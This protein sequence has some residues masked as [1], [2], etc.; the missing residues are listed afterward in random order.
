MLNNYDE[1]NYVSV[2]NGFNGIYYFDEQLETIR[3]VSITNAN[4]FNLFY[5]EEYGTLY[6][7]NADNI[8]FKDNNTLNLLT[9]DEFGNVIVVKNIDMLEVYA[10]QNEFGER[11]IYYEKPYSLSSYPEL[12]NNVTS[13]IEKYKTETIGFQIDRVFILTFFNPNREFTDSELIELKKV[14]SFVSFTK[15]EI[16]DISGNIYEIE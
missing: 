8:M 10:Y 12:Y 15:I 13:K 9:I 5:D 2:D 7:K 16:S 1:E 4:Y 14:E 6:Y 11:R 3:N